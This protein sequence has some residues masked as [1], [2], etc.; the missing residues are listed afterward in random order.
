MGYHKSSG[1]LKLAGVQYVAQKAPLELWRLPARTQSPKE[2]FRWYSTHVA[3]LIEVGRW[4][5]G[6]SLL[7]AA[8]AF[9]EDAS[10]NEQECGAEGAGQSNEDDETDCKIAT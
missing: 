2:I 5:W 8:V 1:K 4:R 9:D 3:C 6:V 7:L 10:H